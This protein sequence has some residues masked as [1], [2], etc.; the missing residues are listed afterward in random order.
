MSRSNEV[1]ATQSDQRRGACAVRSGLARGEG[2]MAPALLIASTAEGDYG[3]L[4]LKEP[5]FDLTDRGV[6][7][8][9]APGR[10]MP[11]SYTERGVY[12]SGETVHVTAL[13]RDAEGRGGRRPAADARRR[14]AGRRRI[15]ARRRRRRGLGG[16]SLAV[17]LAAR[18]ASGTWRVRAFTDPKRRRSA[19]RPS[20]SRTTCPSGSNSTSPQARR[21]SRRLAGPDRRRRALSLRRAGARTSTSKA[22]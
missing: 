12:R 17:A 6:A 7:G 14:A 19:R 3:F 5:A 13:L 18:R 2:G 15:P 4:N 8:R 1:L 10:S 11:S 22:N 16:R 20:W 21:R 9:Q